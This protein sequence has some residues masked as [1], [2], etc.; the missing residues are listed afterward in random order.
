MSL[1]VMPGTVHAVL[2][3]NGAGK[4]T[5]M[6]VLAGVARAESGEI[7]FY[8]EAISI[9]SPN[10]ARG[11]RDEHRH[12]QPGNQPVPTAIRACEFIRE[13]RTAPLRPDL[14]TT[15]GG[16]RRQLLAQLGLQVD[17]SSHS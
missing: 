11:T 7:A 17:V 10:E 12:R 1:E 9:G 4:S 14:D 13:L 8:G 3:E 16:A 6:K 2:G 15:D 5:L